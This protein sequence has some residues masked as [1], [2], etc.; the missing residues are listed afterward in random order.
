MKI[1]DRALI[2]AYNAH[3]GQTR[4]YSGEPYICHSIAVAATLEKFGYDEDVQIAGL[5]HD[6]IEDTHYNFADIYEEF[7][8]KIA[9]LVL[10]VSDISKPS[11][12]NRAIRKTIDREHLKNAS[13]EGKAIK[14]ADLIDNT[15]N[16]TAHDKNF[17]KIYLQEKSLL[18]DILKDVNG[19]LLVEAHKVYHEAYNTLMFCKD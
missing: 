18:L 3:R 10:E 15:K 5:F 4:K 17:A 14:L 9:K 6:I 2:F 7:N 12:G 1:F 13:L 16:I 19:P 11:D 8:L